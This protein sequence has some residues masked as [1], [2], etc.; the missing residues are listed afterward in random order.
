MATSR[1]IPDTTMGGAQRSDR[2]TITCV[3]ST[4]Y[5]RASRPCM[6]SSGCMKWKL[7]AEK[8]ISPA[9]YGLDVAS[10]N[11]DLVEIVLLW[12]VQLPDWADSDHLRLPAQ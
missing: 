7:P 8:S 12:R 9:S 1:G 6:I 3:Q 10:T 4:V 5:Q 2:S 11:R